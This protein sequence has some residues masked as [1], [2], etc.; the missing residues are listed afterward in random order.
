MNI[1]I[2]TG[3]FEPEHGGP[4]TISKFLARELT[5]M[6][7]NVLILTYSDQS[8]CE[9]DNI[10]NF[11]VK[12]IKRIRGFI[13]KVLTYLNFFLNLIFIINKYDIVYTLDW[14]ASGIPVLISSKITGKKYFVRV[15]GDYI[16]EK[17]IQEGN[18]PMSINAF[19]EQRLYKKYKLLY[20]LISKV[21]RNSKKVIFNS[22][23]QSE[24]FAQHYHLNKNSIE[25]VYNPINNYSN[26]RWSGNKSSEIIFAGRI[27]SVKNI[28]NFI[29]AFEKAGVNGLVLSI[30]GDG[31][32]MDKILNI[33][34]EN[35]LGDRVKVF[36]GMTDNELKTKILQCKYIVLP[37]WTDVSPNQ[38]YEAISMGVPMLITKENFLK[39]HNSIPF[40]M[41][42]AS[43]DDMASKIAL[44][45][46]SD[47]FEKLCNYYGA[48]LN[49][50]K[51]EF[52]NRHL[53]I[54]GIK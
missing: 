41:D 34:S 44:I 19:N 46:N 48:P 26:G 30:I 32:D 10:L 53:N 31:P 35:N 49:N 24:I 45:E 4:A 36:K 16:W 9:S 37:S 18:I 38:F 6:G 50:D 2:A 3:I 33:I 39:E 21:L 14:F 29:K 20:R 12:R 27:V 17:Y 15:G 51:D 5:S 22:K 1:L 11:K 42:P 40:M 8:A 23:I 7:H 54:L 13:G 28:I 25:V 47:N 52:I 43:I